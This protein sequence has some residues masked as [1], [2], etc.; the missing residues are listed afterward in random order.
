MW[1]LLLACQNAPTAA[2]PAS[3]LPTVEA[4]RVSSG[5]VQ[6]YLARPLDRSRTW[7]GVLVQ[8]EALDPTTLGVIRAEADGGAVAL[9]VDASADVAAALD[10]LR[11]LP[12]VSDEPRVLCLREPSRCVSPPP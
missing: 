12:A 6:G 10:Y 8:V 7:P 11:A 4:R 2:L 5:A 9:G 1:L 3:A